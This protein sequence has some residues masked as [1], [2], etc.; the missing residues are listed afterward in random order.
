MNTNIQWRSQTTSLG[1]LNVHLPPLRAC[2][3]RPPLRSSARRCSAARLRPPAAGRRLALKGTDGTL[4]AYV[5]GS[6]T[7][8]VTQR[9]RWNSSRVRV[10][11]HLHILAVGLYML[12]DPRLP[13]A[14]GRLMTSHAS[15]D[16][17]CIEDASQD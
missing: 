16:K 13:W 3:R 5:G 2:A 9:N 15:C 6:R 1:G 8:L 17:E 12:L 11:L 14:R 7:C 4:L 10:G